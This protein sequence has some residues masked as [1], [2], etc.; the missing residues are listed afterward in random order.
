[1]LNAS[2]HEL[3]AHDDVI[4]QIDKASGGQAVWRTLENPVA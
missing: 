4:N 2:E 3:A 1:V